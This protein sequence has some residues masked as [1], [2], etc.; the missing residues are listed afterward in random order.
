[1]Q[2]ERSLVRA[3]AIVAVAWQGLGAGSVIIR[4]LVET[5]AWQYLGAPAWA[6]FSR[7]AD[8][9]PGMVVYSLFG[10]VSWVVVLAMAVVFSIDRKANRAASVPVYLAALFAMVSLI[11]TA[12]AAPTMIGIRG[13]AHDAT[14]LQAAFARFTL[15]G[16]YVRGAAFALSFLSSL[17]ALVTL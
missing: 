1:M 5:P 6:D 14:A 12:I 13:L 7:K 11:T 3:L 15:W 17:A 8:L 16:V 2:R 4:A 10:I 9:G